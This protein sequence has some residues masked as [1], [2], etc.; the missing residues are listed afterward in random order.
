MK[1]FENIPIY[2]KADEIYKLVSL[3][4]DLIPEDDK[5]LSFKKEILLENA[6]IIVVKTVGGLQTKVY[7]MKMENA[8]LIRKS[9]REL[10]VAYHGLEAF[11]FKDAKYYQMVRDLID[12]FKILFIDWVAG[13]NQKH[14]IVDEWGLFNPPG[15]T[16]DYEQRSDEF[17]FLDE[18]DEE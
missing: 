17:N 10:Y 16:P 8:T 3:I 13:F 7:D 4:C 9:A 12:E 18:D 2:Q 14:F 5:I 1:K 11:G 6:L 15:I